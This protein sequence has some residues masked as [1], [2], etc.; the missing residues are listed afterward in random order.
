ML[1]APRE[2]P[3][4]DFAALVGRFSPRTTVVEGGT[5]EVSVD[6]Q[7]LHFFDPTNGAAIYSQD[8]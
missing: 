7:A 5:V 2:D 4:G 3:D 1:E 8:T 6:P